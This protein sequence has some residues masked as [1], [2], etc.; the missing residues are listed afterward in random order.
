MLETGATVAW[1]LGAM[2][3]LKARMWCEPGRAWMHLTKE[4][5]AEL[6]DREAKDKDRR[7]RGKRPPPTQGSLF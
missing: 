2:L 1:P 4:Q 3:P 5:L 7:K 6:A